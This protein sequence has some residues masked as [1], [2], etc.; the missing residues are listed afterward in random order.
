MVGVWV[1][2]GGVWVHDCDEV[3]VGVW[4]RG[5]GKVMEVVMLRQ[6][7]GILR[8]CEEHG[9]EAIVTWSSN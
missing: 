1:S 2:C 7:L 3:M 6:K 8:V 4:V 9:Y 5:G